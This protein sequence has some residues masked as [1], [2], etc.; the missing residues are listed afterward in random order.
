MLSVRA[1]DVFDAKAVNNKSECNGLCRMA[2]KA[3]SVLGRFIGE[4]LDEPIL[5]AW[6]RRTWICGFP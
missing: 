6:G 1:T 2:E 3:K 4:M 5:P